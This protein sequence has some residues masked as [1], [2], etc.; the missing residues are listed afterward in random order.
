MRLT[1]LDLIDG[2]DIL[3]EDNNVG[4]MSRWDEESD[5]DGSSNN[6]DEDDD[7]DEKDDNNENG[8]VYFDGKHRWR[9]SSG[10]YELVGKD[11]NSETTS[12]QDDSFSFAEVFITN[13]LI[14]PFIEIS[15]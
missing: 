6:D 9:K 10:G 11:I 3:G 7:V 13:S 1:Q 8:S 5:S 12:T 4:L 14:Y 2:L 15:L